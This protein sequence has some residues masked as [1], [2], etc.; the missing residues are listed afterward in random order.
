MIYHI[1]QEQAWHMVQ[2][3][4]IYQPASLKAEGFIHFSTLAQSLGVANRFYAG[5]KSLLLLA[6]N[7]GLVSAE[8][9][10]ED[11]Y[12]HGDKFPHL[13]GS[14]DPEAVVAVH[15]LITNNDGSISLPDE[16][17]NQGARTSGN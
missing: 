14:L 3:A 2:K 6:V 1:I 11:L 17:T 4:G 9:V 7:E 16:L 5:Q 12:G 15:K 8:I 10:Y 13:Y